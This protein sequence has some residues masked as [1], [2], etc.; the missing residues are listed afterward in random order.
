MANSAKLAGLKLV[1]EDA[2]RITR[3]RFNDQI[4]DHEAKENE[5][6]TREGVTEGTPVRK[7][8]LVNPSEP[9]LANFEGKVES[10]LSG[11]KPSVEKQA[12]T[13]SLTTSESASS[14]KGGK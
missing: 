7:A 13:P 10:T 9:D 8:A 12:N 3:Q 2:A 14:N 6:N 1:R 5:V 4:N 11:V